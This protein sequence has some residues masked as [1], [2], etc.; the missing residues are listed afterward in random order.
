M[1]SKCFKETHIFMSESE[2]SRQHQVYYIL[3][4]AL[5]DRVAAYS[6]SWMCVYDLF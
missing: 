1:V 3:M 5:E 6:G 4:S 2:H